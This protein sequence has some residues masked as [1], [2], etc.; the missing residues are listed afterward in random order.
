MMGMPTDENAPM[1]NAL[2]VIEAKAGAALQSSTRRDGFDTNEAPRPDGIKK[3]IGGSER[4]GFGNILQ[5]V[6]TGYAS[7]KYKYMG[8]QSN[9]W[10]IGY[11]SKNHW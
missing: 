5:D 7:Q 10:G 1:V 4:R 2:S 8:I 9:N 3:V 6:F 11:G